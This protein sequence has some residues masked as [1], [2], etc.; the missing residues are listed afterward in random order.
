MRYL[1]A[2]CAALGLALAV[3]V[4]AADG[5]A[6]RT[7]TTTGVVYIREVLGALPISRNGIGTTSTDGLVLR[8]TTAAA[9][10]AQQYSPRLCWEGRGWKTDATAAS[11][12]V[13]F[14]A[15]TQPVQGAAAPTGNLI[16]KAAINGGAFATV[17]TF[18]SGGAWT[19]PSTID[20]TGNISG[21]SLV[22]LAAQD[23][24]F[25]GRNRFSSPAD[26]STRIRN[27]GGTNTYDVV[28]TD[29]GTTLSAEAVSYAQDGVQNIGTA[30]G[31]LSIT[32]G[33]AN[34]ACLYMLSGTATTEVSDPDT[35]CTVTK[36]NAATVNISWQTDHFEIENKIAGTRTIRAVLIGG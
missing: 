4:V 20:A 2:V 3:D 35:L 7:I 8:N 6:T 33:T 5:Q 14:C 12:S 28:L 24:L 25:S 9:A 15:E 29:W 32:I 16:I 17:A 11:Q 1:K 18:G 22:A 31:L 21:S 36:G 34:A 19:A 27:A 26:G 23:I 13:V 30:R 10:G